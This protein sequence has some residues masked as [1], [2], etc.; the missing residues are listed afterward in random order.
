MS[1]STS[2]ATTSGSRPC[3]RRAPA[4]S[5]ST[6]RNRRSASPTF[7][8][9]SWSSCRT[10]RSQHKNRA[11][12][13]NILRS[14]IYDAE[15][16]A[17]TPCARPIAARTGRLRRPLRAHPHLQFS[18]GPRHRPPHQP[19]ALQAAAGDR[20]RSARRTDRRAD[21]R[22]SGRPARRRRAPRRERLV[23]DA[24]RRSGA[25]TTRGTVSKPRDQFRRARRAAVDRRGARTRSHRPDRSRE[26][27][28]HPGR[29]PIAS[30][31]RAAPSRRRAGRAH[32]RPQGILGTVAATFA[33]DAGAAARHRNRGRTGARNIARRLAL[34]IAR[35]GSPISAPAPARSCWRCCRSCRRPSGSAPTSRPAPCKPRKPMRR[36][37]DWRIAPVSSP[38]T[39]PAACPA[40]ST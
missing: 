17:S 40:R 27:D 10:S 18:A 39:M 20:G 15:R 26:P 2:R 8:P 12:A 19:D 11:S 9:A 33:G 4:A 25:A 28:A 16:S 24:D 34:P 7:R 31:H 3:A 30:N 36:A 32:P 1:T 5:T 21:H 14:R 37:R 23:A 22:A 29:S 6:R 38:A 13:M 35:C